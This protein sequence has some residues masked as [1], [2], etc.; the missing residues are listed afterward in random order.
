MFKSC[1]RFFSSLATSVKL[2]AFFLEIAIIDLV[3]FIKY[4]QIKEA[5]KRV[6][7][8]VP[9][10]IQFEDALVYVCTILVE[11]GEISYPMSCLGGFEWQDKQWKISPV[12]WDKVIGVLVADGYV[13]RVN[14]ATG[15]SGRPTAFYVADNLKGIKE[16]AQYG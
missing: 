4:M 15:G 2:V 9:R 5:L 7:G 16:I 8:E 1:P 6:K 14:R 11:N 12:M 10:S 3:V 13:H